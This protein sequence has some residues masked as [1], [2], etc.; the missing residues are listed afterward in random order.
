M[1]GRAGGVAWRV[2]LYTA[3]LFVS[4]AGDNFLDTRECRSIF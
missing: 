3:S 2:M 4:E 1:R